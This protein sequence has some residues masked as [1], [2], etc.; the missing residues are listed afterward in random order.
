MSEPSI[1][2][3]RIEA[4]LIDAET[5]V[6]KELR[7]KDWFRSLPLD[8]FNALPRLSNEEIQAALDKGRPLPPIGGDWNP[9]LRF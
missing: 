5:L 4:T 1:S 3:D 2:P 7:K 8:E 9:G 6:D